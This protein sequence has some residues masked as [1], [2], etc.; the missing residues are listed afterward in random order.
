MYALVRK[1]SFS[2]AQ[3]LREIGSRWCAILKVCFSSA[4][5]SFAAST[6][7]LLTGPVTAAFTVKL[8]FWPRIILSSL[9]DFHCDHVQPI[10]S[11]SLIPSAKW[12]TAHFAHSPYMHSFENVL[13]A[14]A[15]SVVDRSAAW[16]TFNDD[17]VAKANAQLSCNLH[18]HACHVHLV[19][20]PR[21][22]AYGK[23]GN[24]S[25]H[26]QLALQET[27]CAN[28]VGCHTEV[29]FVSCHLSTLVFPSSA[30]CT[31]VIFTNVEFKDSSMFCMDAW[32]TVDQVWQSWWSI[33]STEYGCFRLL[34]FPSLRTFQA[35]RSALLS[36]CPL[37]Q[38]AYWFHISIFFLFC[39]C[40]FLLLYTCTHF[41]YQGLHRVIVDSVVLFS[42]ADRCHEL[43]LKEPV[44]LNKYCLV[45]ILK[46]SRHHIYH[47]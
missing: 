13:H 29:S 28:S 15:L 23:T 21:I 33:K 3:G 38:L 12:S 30:G 20:P 34:L 43:V 11:A 4:V 7:R 26:N 39:P 2:K 46:S 35:P 22:G 24:N 17:S 42:S 27:L 8:F 37:A 47:I 40:F 32:T 31:A 14:D 9:T 6:I 5:T 36:L 18:R 16:M 44:K 41:L 45:K 19:C 1:S 10:S 25:C